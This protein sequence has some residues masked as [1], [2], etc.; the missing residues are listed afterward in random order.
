MVISTYDGGP[1]RDYGYG[2]SKHGF[3]YAINDTWTLGLMQNGED[4]EGENYLRLM[5]KIQYEK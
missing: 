5:G 2:N 1:R 3:G 4:A